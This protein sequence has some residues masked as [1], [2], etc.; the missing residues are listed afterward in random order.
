MTTGRSRANFCSPSGGDIS[1]AI[2]KAAR[3]ED[4]GAEIRR[5]D[6]VEQHVDE[7]NITTF[8]PT[9]RK[10]EQF[11][12][13]EYNAVAQPEENW[14]VTQY[15]SVQV[16]IQ[17]MF[18]SV[19]EPW[20]ITNQFT[21]IIAVQEE[22]VPSLTSLTPVVSH[23]EEWDISSYTEGAFTG[24]EEWDTIPLMTCIPQHIDEW[25]FTTT[26]VVDSTSGQFDE[27]W[28]NT[29]DFS[30]GTGNQFD[31]E[32]EL[33]TYNAVVAFGEDGWEFNTAYIVDSTSAQF[34]EEWEVTMYLAEDS[35]GPLGFFFDEEWE[36]T[37][38]LAE[39]SFGPL[40]NFFD[41][42]WES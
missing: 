26:Y 17:T 31:E 19:T 5:F 2:C 36:V 15:N 23:V 24:P 11:D 7:W 16:V 29:V 34:D 4:V 38:Y 28:P 40:G 35:S 12:F 41:E 37:N 14:D 18:P 10:D 6:I 33:T 30:F 8:S 20:E 25:E 27:E 9:I 39:D 42:E 21:H 3:R 22:W 13:T 1:F 32:W